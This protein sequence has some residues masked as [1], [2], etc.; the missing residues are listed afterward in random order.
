[1]L[2]G[3][4]PFDV[5]HPML[6]AW[7]EAG[8]GPC[9]ACITDID[10][11]GSTNVIDLLAIIATWGPCKFCPEDFNEDGTVDVSDLLLVISNW[12]ECE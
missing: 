6:H 1:M 9:I 2:A 10:G 8:E 7:F 12:G 3:S 5:D 11:D 4:P